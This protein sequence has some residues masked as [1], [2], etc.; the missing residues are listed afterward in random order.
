[1]VN[2]GPKAAELDA[3]E[4]SAKAIQRLIQLVDSRDEQIALAACQAVLDRAI[5]KP[6]QPVTV[7][8]TIEG[9]TLQDMTDA[10]LLALIRDK[11]ARIDAILRDADDAAPP[12]PTRKH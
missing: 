6:L 12:P 4:G 11:T 9:K 2:R 5:G 1:M 3:H 10:E 8:I 7:S